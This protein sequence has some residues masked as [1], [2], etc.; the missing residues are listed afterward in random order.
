MTKDTWKNGKIS[1]IRIG[2]EIDGQ[3]VDGS[4]LIFDSIELVLAEEADKKPTSYTID[5]TDSLNGF[6]VPAF[7]KNCVA[8]HVDSSLQIRNIQIGR[9]IAQAVLAETIDGTTMDALK[10]RIKNTYGSC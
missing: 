5:F 1:Q 9:L 8:E 3:F 6:V 4:A 10:I 2:F 7:I